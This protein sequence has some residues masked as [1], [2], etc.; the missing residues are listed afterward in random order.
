[1]APLRRDPASERWQ[2]SIVEDGRPTLAP[3]LPWKEIVPPPPARPGALQGGR[4][5]FAL[6]GEGEVA[7][8]KHVRAD[9][10]GHGMAAA[11]AERIELLDVAELEGALFGDPRP[12]ARLECAMRDR[13]KRPEGQG[14]GLAILAG[15]GEDQGLLVVDGDDRRV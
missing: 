15:D 8:R 10:T 4:R 2:Y 13:I 9:V 5:F 11:V 1:F 12:Q 6:A 3:I 7:D 14:V